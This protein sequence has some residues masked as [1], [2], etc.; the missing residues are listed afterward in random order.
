M[1][2]SKDLFRI[3]QKHNDLLITGAENGCTF[4]IPLLPDIYGKT[5]IDLCIG[6]H[7]SYKSIFAEDKRDRKD[8][9]RLQNIAM[10]EVLF[11]GI[12]N[13]GFMHSS[14]FIS[15]AVTKATSLGLKSIKK[16][17]DFQLCTIDHAFIA[18]TEHE[19]HKK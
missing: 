15:E 19:L 5:A 17:L 4:E 9:L 16:Y 2:T 12:K 14:H 6:M 10:A 3:A 18:P 7:K 11:K 1:I 13:Y 8:H